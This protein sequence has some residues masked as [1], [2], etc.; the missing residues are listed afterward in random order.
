MR[1]PPPHTLLCSY[2]PS[3]PPALRS[4]NSEKRAEE[5]KY[6]MSKE[7]KRKKREED[8]NRKKGGFSSRKQKK[9]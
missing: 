9:G 4:S 8:K 2:R 3:G 1:P 6:E 5:I 7:G